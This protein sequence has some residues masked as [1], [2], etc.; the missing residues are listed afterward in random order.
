[1]GGGGSVVGREEVRWRGEVWLRGEVWCR[2]EV[3]LKQ[4][5]RG[6]ASGC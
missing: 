1:M 6:G 3:R 5:W 2:G 4:K